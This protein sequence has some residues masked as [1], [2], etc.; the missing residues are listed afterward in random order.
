MGW[1]LSTLGS[2][3]LHYGTHV[4]EIYCE[5]AGLSAREPC[6]VPAQFP[7][8]REPCTVPALSLSPFPVIWNLIAAGILFQ[9]PSFAFCIYLCFT[10]TMEGITVFDSFSYLRCKNILH[11]LA[12]VHSIIWITG[13]I[14][15]LF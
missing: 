10:I 1:T 11:S 2:L 13:S 15:I 3:Q 12:I 8:S 5:A 6:T 14:Y 9:F 7:L 4:V